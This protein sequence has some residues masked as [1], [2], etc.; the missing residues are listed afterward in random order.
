[1]KLLDLID[2]LVMPS[3]LEAFYRE[4]GINEESESLSICMQNSL[5]IDSDVAIFGIEETG[6]HINFQKDGI[7]YVDMLPV[8]LAIDL[9]E[10]GL[11]LKHK[12]VTNLDIANRLLEYAIYDA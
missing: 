9:I 12:D 8:D 1:M 6:E 2:Y 10:S 5:S 7:D 4:H 3:K 11:G